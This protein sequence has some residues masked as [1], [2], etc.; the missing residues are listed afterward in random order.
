MV[1]P[2]S[3]AE[4]RYQA[5]IGDDAT[6]A[7]VEGYIAR[8]RGWV[9]RHTGHLLVE[10]PITVA[11]DRF[12]RLRLRE[13]PVK[14]ETA[15]LTYRDRTGATVPLPVRMVAGSRPARILPT[16]GAYW[17][18]CATEADAISVTVTAGYASASDIPGDLVQAML[19]L[20]AAYYVD[21]EGGEVLAASKKS[22]AGF[23]S[24]YR[25][26]GL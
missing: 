12:D 20:I 17:P 22:A 5:R 3:I 21:R 2:V 10:R 24:D 9:E 26:R 6:D 4:A 8:A 16:A 13:W 25:L 15:V 23:C 14:P 18:A 7:T 11:F 19:V 1:E